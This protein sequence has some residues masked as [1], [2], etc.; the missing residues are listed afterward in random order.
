MVVKQW[1]TSNLT[2]GSEVI[3]VAAMNEERKQLEEFTISQWQA[4]RLEVRM[5]SNWLHCRKMKTCMFEW[6]CHTKFSTQNFCLKA[7]SSDNRAL[8]GVS[9]RFRRYSWPW[10]LWNREA[11]WAFTVIPLSRSTW[12]LSNTCLFFSVFAMAPVFQ[13]HPLVA[14]HVNFNHFIN[15]Q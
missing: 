7:S 14:H 10:W 12:S 3:A 9:M 2:K 11:V 6:N 8:T 1:N 5:T 13:W 15:S 4:L